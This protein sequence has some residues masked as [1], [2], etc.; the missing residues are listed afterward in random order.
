MFRSSY[1]MTDVNFESLRS[2]VRIL[3][4]R[5][6]ERDFDENLMSYP[7]FVDESNEKVFRQEC[8]EVSVHSDFK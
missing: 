5:V 1:A 2:D 3:L 7:Y 4:M 8:G 6:M